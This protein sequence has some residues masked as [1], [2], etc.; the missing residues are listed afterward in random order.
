M[1]RYGRKVKL[2]VIYSADETAVNPNMLKRV[3]FFQAPNP[4]ASGKLAEAIKKSTNKEL[5]EMHELYTNVHSL[6]FA[7]D[8][9]NSIKDVKKFIKKRLH[10][11]KDIALLKGTNYYMIMQQHEQLRAAIGEHLSP[12]DIEFLESQEQEQEEI[13]HPLNEKYYPPSEESEEISVPQ[14]FHFEKSKSIS[15]ESPS[16]SEP[17]SRPSSIGYKFYINGAEVANKRQPIFEL[18]KGNLAVF[19]YSD[20]VIE[21]GTGIRRARNFGVQNI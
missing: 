2:M 17:K 6:T 21:T 3:P 1:Y 4:A 14:T 5:V 20:L 19:L 8:Q 18:L 13:I 9:A 15:M 12:E 11:E 7:V 10:S 16:I